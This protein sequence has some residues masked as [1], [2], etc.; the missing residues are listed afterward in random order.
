MVNKIGRTT[1]KAANRITGEKFAIKIIV[2][3]K[4]EN[5]SSFSELQ[6]QSLLEPQ[7]QNGLIDLVDYIIE[8]DFEYL[9]RPFYNHGNIF[10]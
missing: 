4:F 5:S 9:V 7:I 3:K 1:V 10:S 8:D 2:R 6:L